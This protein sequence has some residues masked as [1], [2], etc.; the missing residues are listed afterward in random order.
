MHACVR[1]GVES[2]E[3]LL[4]SVFAENRHESPGL[5]PAFLQHFGAVSSIAVSKLFAELR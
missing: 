1:R 5:G 4:T 3:T 2:N